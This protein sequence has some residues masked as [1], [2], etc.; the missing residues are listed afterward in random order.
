MTQAL[1]FTTLWNSHIINVCSRSALQVVVRDLQV[2]WD[3]SMLRW[4]CNAN[5]IMLNHALTQ[6]MCKTWPMVCLPWCETSVWCRA[7]WSRESPTVH[8]CRGG[9]PEKHR[10]R[11]SKNLK[12]TRD[13]SEFKFI[14][15]SWIFSEQC[16]AYRILTISE[17]SWQIKA[18]LHRQEQRKASDFVSLQPPVAYISA[19]S[20]NCGCWNKIKNQKRNEC[21]PQN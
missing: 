13:I 5:W 10:G 17:F 2:C 12:R 21:D 14:I 9:C 15:T 18:W 16:S 4:G 3:I 19:G 1:T 6:R 20:W 7:A 11:K 8:T